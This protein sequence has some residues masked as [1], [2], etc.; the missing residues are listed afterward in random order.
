MPKKIYLRLLQGGLIASLLIVFAV[1]ADMLFP[2]ITPKQ[3]I[4][5]ILMEV[6]FAFWLIFI[7]RY[8][9]YRPKR[10]YITYGLIAYFLAIL[11]SCAVSVDINLSFWGDAERMLGFF[12][13]FHFFIFYLILISV[14]RSWKEWQALLLSS[15][16]VATVVSAKGLWGGNVYSSIGNTTYVSGYLIFN[17]FFSLL[18]FFRSKRGLLHWLYL[19][20][21]GIMLAEF[22]SCHTSGAIIGLFFSLLLMFFLLGLFHKNRS[23]RRASLLIS[24]V[25]VLGVVILFSQYQAAWFQNSFLKNLTFQKA[26]FQTRLISWQSAAKDF[27]NHP[28]FGTGFGNYAVIFDKHFDPRF[29]DYATTETYFDRAH[30]NLVDIIS[31]TGLV[32]LLTYLSIFI[33]AL[34]Y[35]LREFNHNGRRAGTEGN[36]P[37]RNLE[38][39]IIVSLLAAYFI[40]NLAV[41]DSFVTYIGLMIT[42]GFIHWSVQERE[43]SAEGEIELRAPII[44]AQWELTFL[45][46]VLS[47]ILL[48]VNHY[49]LKPWR[50]F[51]GVITG[52][53]HILDG[54]TSRGLAAYRRALSGT[55][56]DRDGRTTLYTFVFSNP[57]VLN[58]LSAKEAAAFLEYAVSLAEENV[59]HNPQDSMAQMHL[60]QVSDVAARYHYQDLIQ[61]NQ[62]SARAM[63]A[64][65]NAIESSPGRAPVYLVKSQILL[66]RGENEEAIRVI[67]HAISL[68]PN[69]NEGYCRLAQ[70]YLFLEEKDKVEDPLRRCAD[71]GGANQINSASL[72]IAA[73]DY[74][75]LEEDYEYALQFAHRLVY[76]YENNGEVW[77]I[78]AKLYH[79]AGEEEIAAQAAEN[80]IILTPGL[81]DDWE[82]FLAQAKKLKK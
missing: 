70:F 36:G 48:F 75:A 58:T 68:N 78:L 56:L 8:P 26:T 64:I 42:L 44:G 16:L 31:T 29:F 53:G 3:L 13:L 24:V 17:L 10:S 47:L 15:V 21:V 30:N 66:G 55:P 59:A 9:E 60:A 73:A 51:Q 25:A 39:I 69:Y 27:H 41:F 4:F 82:S 52:Y 49:N 79:I 33:A 72:L 32:G 43:V 34:Y 45:I 57:D 11:A 19:L 22:W 46:I 50:M 71:L 7:L 6:L 37:R 67:E 1:F 2:F 54:E 63:N 76:L 28:L 38:I 77:L 12:H 35:L 20:P 40:Q 5:N 62:Y 61:F 14:F 18:L 65:D 74:F 80:A 81:Q 23:L